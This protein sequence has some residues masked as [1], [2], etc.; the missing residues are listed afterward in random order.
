MSGLLTARPADP[1]QADLPRFVTVSDAADLVQVAT[2]TVYRELDDFPCIRVRGR[3]VIPSRAVKA[4]E[5]AALAGRDV[6][7][8]DWDFG[9]ETG[10]AFY[11]MRAAARLLTL[12]PE[13]LKREITAK[14]FPVVRIRGCWVVPARALDAMERRALESW[15][16]VSAMEF[17]GPNSA[18][19]IGVA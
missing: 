4:V 2:N 3:W 14:R 11:K 17:A 16:P 12:S 7:T 5:T 18:I 1:H 6:E 8:G 15:G 10:L 19:S 9:W 13:T